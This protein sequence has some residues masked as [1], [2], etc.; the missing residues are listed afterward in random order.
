MSIPDT[1]PI[2]LLVYTSEYTGS[3]EQIDA[4]IADILAAARRNNV[5]NG[6]TGVLFHHNRRFL[7]FIEGPKH[8]INLLLEKIGKDPRHSSV[9]LLFDEIISER[10]FG[11]WSMDSFNLQ[12][13]QAL[14]TDLLKMIRDAYR[15]N[16]ITRTHTL[17]GIY[18]GFIEQ[19][20]QL[21]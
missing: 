11:D 17:V 4:D 12:A 19:H 7:Q 2:H 1:S 8:S 21:L 16:F 15:R 13:S 18:K 9:E 3:D 14:D 20:Q 6:I 10:G 5:R